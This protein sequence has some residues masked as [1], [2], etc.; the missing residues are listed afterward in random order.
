MFKVNL[1]TLTIINVTYVHIQ[2]IIIPFRSY[3]R[4]YTNGNPNIVRFYAFGGGHQLGQGHRVKSKP[5]CVP[6]GYGVTDLM[7]KRYLYYLTS[8]ETYMA[9]TNLKYH[10]TLDHHTYEHNQNPTPIR[11]TLTFKAHVCSI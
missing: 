7:S 10:R 9:Y 3:P 5:M 6:Y 4:P 1:T 11:K 8:T 2:K